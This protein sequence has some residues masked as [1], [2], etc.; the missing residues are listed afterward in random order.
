M[1]ES[2]NLLA[3]FNIEVAYI[4]GVKFTILVLFYLV[5]VI[6]W[7]AYQRKKLQSIDSTSTTLQHFLQTLQEAEQHA[8]DTPIKEA[9]DTYFN[10]LSEADAHKSLQ[11]AWEEFSEGL[12]HYNN[13]WM[14]VYQA[15]DFFHEKWLIE[16]ILQP[17][18]H[19][20]GFAT[21][22]GLLFTFL[23]ITA[24]LSELHYDNTTHLV[25]DG[26][27]TFINALSSKFITSLCG[28]GLALG[29]DTTIRNKEK[30]LHQTLDDIVYHLNRSF[31]RL[32]A[33]HILIG[34]QGDVHDLPQQ[35]GEHLDKTS[36]DSG[37]IKN[38]EI[39][40]KTGIEGSVAEIKTEINQVATAMEGFSSTGI[41]NIAN[42]LE[43][44]GKDLKTGVTDGINNDLQQLTNIMNE[45]PNKITDAM[46]NIDSSIGSMKISMAD[47]QQEMLT[48]VKE[49]F[50]TLQ[51]TQG[52]QLEAL[53]ASFLT[54]NDTLTTQLVAQ[55]QEMQQK[56]EASM[57]VINT[58]LARL[59]SAGATQQQQLNDT[60]QTQLATT[61]T[62]FNQV[63]E[64]FNQTTQ[65][66]QQ[67]VNEQLAG[68]MEKITHSGDAFNDK[69]QASLAG[70]L[71][72]LQTSVEAFS[73]VSKQFPQ[74]L[75]EGQNRLNQAFAQLEG[76]LTNEFT[77]F[78]NQQNSLTAQQQT[79]LQT[80]AD[81]LRQVAQLQAE[82]AK[83]QG[84]LEQIVQLE[85]QLT[86][87]QTQQNTVTTDNLATLRYALE[88]Q[89]ATIAQHQTM[90]ETLQQ[91][92]GTLNKTAET[93]AQTFGTAG[94]A[95]AESITDVQQAS[96][97]Y[98]ANFAAQ[99]RKAIDALA[100]FIEQLQDTTE[101]PFVGTK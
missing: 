83:M 89:Q 53:L 69:L 39:A 84:V 72:E 40:I 23:A 57:Q 96:T 92:Y 51:A 11:H 88:Q 38:I 94:S 67:S 5:M 45:L 91:Q 41:Q 52:E 25:T 65:Q 75:N 43:A 46:H 100:S 3:F 24:G 59:E 74:Q 47:T 86:T 10:Q 56:H 81:Y 99:H 101:R 7:C 13:R 48:L 35:I 71:T 93:I 18:R 17:V 76:L 34:I 1:T 90:A 27:D 49:V 98:F 66:Q 64:N 42:T 87:L 26:L 55:Q 44:L 60:L 50:G 4:F 6:V 21:S 80:L 9:I 85:S 29:L 14:N 32:T 28:L 22:F 78:V 95:M 82:S 37:L 15:E 79:A 8:D 16:P 19:L 61:T 62:S 73:T 33:Q 77:T 70:V 12:Q 2:F 58:M 54:K 30:A 63:L 36:A 97:D 68:V 20:P 31:V